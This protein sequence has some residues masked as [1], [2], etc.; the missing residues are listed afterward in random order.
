MSEE[1]DKRRLTHN[2]AKQK[3]LNKESQTG[4]KK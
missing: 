2:D 1:I 4:I 3:Q